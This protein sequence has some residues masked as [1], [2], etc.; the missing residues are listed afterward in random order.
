MSNIAKRNRIKGFAALGAVAF[1]ALWL[2]LWM[3]FPME[4]YSLFFVS[5]VGSYA[6]VILTSSVLILPFCWILTFAASAD[7]PFWLDYVLNV[8][9]MTA[10]FFL[11]SAFRYSMPF[12]IVTAGVLHICG[13]VFVVGRSEIFK[14]GRITLKSKEQPV[15]TGELMMK[16]QPFRTVLWAVVHTVVIDVAVVFLLWN[17]AYIFYN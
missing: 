5:T 3:I 10:V 7:I 13:M 1:A 9:F 2:V 6:V 14:S 16:K 15:G 8:I 4:F 17:M 11:Y 12:L